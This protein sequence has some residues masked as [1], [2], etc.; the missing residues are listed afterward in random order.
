MLLVF[1]GLAIGLVICECISKNKYQHSLLEWGAIG[2]MSAPFIL[3]AVAQELYKH[4]YPEGWY[5]VASVSLCLI[6]LALIVMQ[7]AS[8]IRTMG[9]ALGLIGSVFLLSLAWFMVLGLFVFKTFEFIGNIFPQETPE[10]KHLREE[11]EEDRTRR[12]MD[13]MKEEDSRRSYFH[14]R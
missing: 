7:T 12:M 13:E 11:E 3:V 5:V 9:W 4:R 14:H 2:T 6:G 10:Q 1:A 8:N